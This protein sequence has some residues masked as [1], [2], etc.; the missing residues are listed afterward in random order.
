MYQAVFYDKN[1]KQ[2]YLRDD[3][4]DGFKTVQHWPTY[5]VADPDGEFVTL[6]GTPVSPVKKM[7]DWKD[8]KYYEKDVE[9][10]TRFLVDHYYETDDTPKSHNIVYLDIECEGGELEIYSDKGKK[11]VETID[12]KTTTTPDTKNIVMFNGGL[13]HKPRQITNGKR[14]IVSYQIRQDKP[15]GSRGGGHPPT[16]ITARRFNH[17]SIGEYLDSCPNDDYE[18]DSET[19]NWSA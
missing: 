3:R 16:T 12:V 18:E 11:V 13:Y 17:P 1:E 2:Y 15:L 10:L 14:V 7:D 8:P 19:N 5:Y 6:E 9:K 4:W